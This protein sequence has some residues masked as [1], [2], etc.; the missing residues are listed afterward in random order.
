MISFL[1]K[2]KGNLFF[3][4]IL[5]LLFIPQTGTPI[6]VFMQR[7]ISFSPSEIATKERILLKDY[8]W[9]LAGLHTNAKNLATSEGKVVL[10]N[11]W[12]TWCP[13]CLAE[14]PS[15][16]KL[17][18]SYGDRVDFYFITNEEASVVTKFMEKQAYT[19]PVYL[20]QTQAPEAIRTNSLPTTYVLSKEKEIVI[21]KTGAADWN[22]EKTNTLLDRLL[23]E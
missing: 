20:Q 3:L 17:Y 14:M 19:F 4:A 21:N 6:R 15:L 11:F 2:H 7:L 18:N 22:S 10:I 16:Q 23:S 8:N 9:K 5:A 13:P 1:K 12:A